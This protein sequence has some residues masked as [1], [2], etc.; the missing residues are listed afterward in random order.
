[1]SPSPSAPFGSARGRVR[2]GDKEDEGREGEICDLDER[3]IGEGALRSNAI[4]D[5]SGSDHDVHHLP[6]LILLTNISN[7][8]TTTN[9]SQVSNGRTSGLSSV[10]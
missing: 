10:Y 4:I 5:H 7:D 2:G 9:I 1:M 8:Q 6:H 3:V